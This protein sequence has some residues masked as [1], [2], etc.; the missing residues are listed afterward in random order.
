MDRERSQSTID[1]DLNP[2]AEFIENNETSPADLE[3]EERL[4]DW[5]EINRIENSTPVATLYKLIGDTGEQR[6]QADYFRGVIPSR[7]EIGLEYGPGR[8]ILIIRN[9]TG[10][11]GAKST[12][13]RFRLHESYTEKSLKFKRERAEKERLALGQPNAVQS[14]LPATTGK[15]SLIE[16]FTLVR[17]MQA[18]TLAMFKPILERILTPATSPLAI[19]A[20]KSPF[21]D[22]ALSRQIMKD[23]LKESMA[24]INQMQKVMIESHNSGNNGFDEEEDTQRPEDPKQSMFDKIIAL[25][26]PFINILAQNNMAAK[27]AAA[28][29][30]AA[31]QFKEVIKDAGL[32]RRIITY[33]EQKE[34]PQRAGI[35]L[36]NLGI[37]REDYI[38]PT[39]SGGPT[40]HLPAPTG[41]KQGD[42][43]QGPGQGPRQGPRQGR[44]QKTGPAP[45]AGEV[46]K[47]NP[48]MEVKA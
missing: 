26:E 4:A 21:E 15:E 7:H 47:L 5:L 34:G 39:T 16:A 45:K 31:P 46:R 32:A 11:K 22:Y 42:T 35:A 27:M 29:I 25:A 13:I 23:S 19:P 44:G 38:T 28:G 8:Y 10:Q 17:S 9:T 3:V 20:P 18:D 6:E 24:M 36:K 37:A 30:K 1:K 43:G 40:A 14:A 2:D 41:K 48:K 33:V 12:S